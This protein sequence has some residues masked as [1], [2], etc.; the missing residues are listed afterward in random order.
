MRAEM[1]DHYV[2]ELRTLYNDRIPG[3]ADLVTY[4]FEKARANIQSGEVKR[5]GLLATNSI[6]S[7]ANRE[8][9]ERIKS[10]GDIFMAWSDRSWILDGAA[11]RVSM[12]CFDNG[13]EKVRDLDGVQQTVINA[14]LTSHVDVTVAGELSENNELCFLGM[15]KAGPF[16][17][18]A[19][20]ARTM[21]SAPIN[22]N[23]R[24]NSDVIKHRLGG[25]DVVQVTRDVWIIDFNEMSM[26]EASCY[27]AP[28]EYVKQYVKPLRD[29][30]NRKRTKERWWLFGET[31]P[32]LRR[33]IQNKKRC[34]V[35]PE[36]SKYR[37][38]I[39]MNTD[40]IPDHKLHVIARDDDYFFGVLQSK[41]HEV[42]TLAQCSWMGVGNDPSYSS[43]RTF[44]TFPFPWPPGQEPKDDQRV[45]A[46][47]LAGLDLVEMRDRW[48]HPAGTSDADRKSRTLTNLYNQRPT[49][50]QLAHQ[51]LDA[52]VCAAYG[53]PDDLSDEQILEKLLV[54]NLERARS[55]SSK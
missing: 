33:A 36:V 7:G 11:V 52:A 4:W 38:F 31:R 41:L 24:S 1:G 8:V 15:M 37:L 28:F 47:A 45:E 18:D 30:N 29:E 50:L 12:V 26:Q 6:R 25:Q 23:G 3:G 32:G 10:S 17:I 20:T 55:Q 48:L 14:D 49:W 16:D 51:R 43:S 34:I 21:L 9:L 39:W 53:W 42:W 13:T 19:D 2:D 40:I 44:E 22:P 46:I 54:L 35:T 27:E 5:A